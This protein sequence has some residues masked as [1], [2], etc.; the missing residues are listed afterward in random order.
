VILVVGHLKVAAG[1]RDRFVELSQVAVRQARQHSEC[2]HF[3][4]SADVLDDGR[5]NVAEVW[6][7]RRALDEFRETGP[8]GPMHDLIEAADVVE[9]TVPD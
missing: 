1:Q 8:S 3:V 6:S 7:S 2:L 5:V 9:Y 4:V